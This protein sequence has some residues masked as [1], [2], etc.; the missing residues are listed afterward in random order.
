MSAA[1]LRELAKGNDAHVKS[2][3]G[4]IK[5]SEFPKQDAVLILTCMDPRSNIIDT[6]NL[7]FGPA[8]LRNAGGRATPDALRSMQV[9]ASIMANGQS[10]LGAVAVIHHTDCGLVNFG[11][12][13]IHERMK[14]NAPEHL[15]MQID[16]M[17]HG[18][19]TDVDASI[20]EDMA[21][22]KADPF[23]PKNLEVLGFVHDSFTGKTTE[24]L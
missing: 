22:I 4:S 16:E 14:K 11:N 5:F 24:V 19:F 7:P 21:I 17:D 18:G 1:M 15:H 12:E 3:P 9:L 6:W 2:F 10:T 13:F 23:L 8:I 20:K